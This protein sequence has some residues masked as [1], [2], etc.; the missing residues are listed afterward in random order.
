MT[1]SARKPVSG[2]LIQ[3]RIRAAIANLFI[4]DTLSMPVHWFYNPGD[5][6]RAFPPHGIRQPEA[7]PKFHPSSIM[8]LHSTSQGGRSRSSFKAS[9]RQPKTTNVV[10]DIIL[11]GRAHLWGQKNAHYHHGLQAGENTLNAWWAMEMLDWISGQRSYSAEDWAE[12]YIQFMTEDPPSHPD[13]YAES[14]HRGFF[15]NWAAGVAPLECGA[16]THDTPSMGALVTVAPLAIALMATHSLEEVQAL[17]RS[18]VWLTHPD[19]QL[20]RVIDAYVQLLDRLLHADEQTETAHYFVEAAAA[21]PGTRLDKLLSDNKPDAHVVGRTYSLACYIS[22]SWPSVCYLAAKYAANP[23]T[24]LLK[25]TN[26]GG[27]N[28]HRGA[29]LGTLTGLVSA[30]YE[31][32]FFDKLAL[33]QSIS[34]SLDRYLERHYPGN[35]DVVTVT[36]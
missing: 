36:V 15:A 30:S 12:R 7:A 21:V 23:N 29:V 26:L 18:H 2:E 17:C 25:N 16:I 24:A 31:H 35:K 4:G 28:A 5:I 1:D 22:D 33:N 14:C 34:Q 19:N 20:M 9:S 8:N 3:R 6:I 13:T 32:S 10:G 27:E 11:K